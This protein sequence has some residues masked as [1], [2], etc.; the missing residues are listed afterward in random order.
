MKYQ[1]TPGWNVFKQIFH[2]HWDEFKQFNPLY[3]KAY[4][5]E[6][7]QKM[8][9][10]GNPEKIGYLDYRCLDCG[11]GKHLVAMSCKSA[12]C[13]RCAKVYVDDFVSHISQRLH[14]GIIY[15]H[16][17]LTLPDRLWDTFYHHSSTLMSEFMR[18]SVRC[19]D[20]FFG[21]LSR[22]PLKGGYIVVL[23]THGRNGQFNPHLHLIATSGG[24]NPEAERWVHLDYLPY[25][26][27]KKKWQWH[28]LTMLRQTLPTPAVRRLVRW[29]FRRYPKGFIAHV[30]DGDVPARYH[31]LATYLAKYVVSPP[32]SVRRIDRYDGR[33]VTY[34]YRSHRTERVEQES[35]DV[36]RFIGRMV[37]HIVPKGFKRVRYYG[38][39][40]AKSFAKLKPVIQAALAQVQHVVRGAVKI[41]APMT[42]R[43]RY[44]HSTGR[45]PL[46]CPHCQGEM[47]LWRMWHPK[48]G[49]IYDEAKRIERGDYEKR[50][51][52]D[53]TDLDRLVA[54]RALA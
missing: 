47:S 31:S 17:I 18:C 50:R 46:R 51:E 6:L 19:M 37:Q 45:D 53:P 43:Q 14:E 28:A 34:H 40:A 54:R 16:T 44:H 25:E 4:Y 12:L 15:R 7:V 20:E 30:Q 9:S 39:Q 52:R 2:D 5:D 23:H 24:W 48:Y 33:R 13:L 42:Y 27:L 36:H 22:Q 1:P 3:N 32:I 49:V 29:C 8:L 35:V 11:Q 41:I 10:C 21:D 38:V 26:L